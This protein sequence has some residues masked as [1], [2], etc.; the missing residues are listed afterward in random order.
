[1]RRQAVALLV[2]KDVTQVNALI[3]I[4]RPSFDIYVH[5]DKKSDITPE[6]I[7]AR[8]VWKEITV[9]WGAYNMIEATVFL[10]R[11]ILATGIPYTH[12]IRQGALVHQVFHVL[13]C[14]DCPLTTRSFKSPDT[15]PD[16]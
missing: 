13:Q 1:M 12:V 8:N 10:Y 6:N 15:S 11:Q 7:D 3:T 4:L 2:H 16:A 5:I 14:E 9:Y